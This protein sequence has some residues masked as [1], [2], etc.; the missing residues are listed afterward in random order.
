MRWVKEQRRPEIS[1][2]EI[3][4]D[5]LGQKFDAEEVQKVLDALVK[6]GWL[7]KDTTKTAGRPIHRWKV[8]AKLFE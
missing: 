8:N 1:R 2:E 3:R 4:R 7:A 6:A 5:A